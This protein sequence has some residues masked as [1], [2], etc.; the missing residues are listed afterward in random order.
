M[1][2]EIIK[3]LGDDASRIMVEHEL[4]QFPSSPLNRLH[5]GKMTADLS[6]RIPPGVSGAR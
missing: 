2:V 1:S 4:E 5:R 3:T 6:G